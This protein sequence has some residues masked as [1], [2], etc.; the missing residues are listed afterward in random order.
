MRRVDGGGR[1]VG[2]NA[3]TLAWNATETLPMS[4]K[5][6]RCSHQASKAGTSSPSP[7]ARAR[8][9]RG[10]AR[11][12]ARRATAMSGPWARAG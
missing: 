4:R 5:A 2:K 12:S 9:A 1:C 3:G 8:A 6:S 11:N 7:A 10:R